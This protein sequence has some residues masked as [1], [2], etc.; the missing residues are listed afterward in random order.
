MYMN[1]YSNKNTILSHVLS[2]FLCNI[3]LKY[4]RVLYT[5]QMTLNRLVIMT[6]FRAKTHFNIKLR[7]L[8]TLGFCWTTGISY[9]P[10]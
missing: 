10:N 8:V 1:M 9:V 7:Y 3:S 4:T 6:S 2:C 5:C